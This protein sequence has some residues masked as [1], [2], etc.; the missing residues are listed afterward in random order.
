MNGVSAVTKEAQKP[1]PPTCEDTVGSGLRSRKQAL[2]DAESWH[3]DLELPASSTV[4]NKCLLFTSLQ[5]T[6]SVIA[7]Q[8]D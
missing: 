1:P 6:V 3:C 8:M 5:S 7:A 2:T 4:R